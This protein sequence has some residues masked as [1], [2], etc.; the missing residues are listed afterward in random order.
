[1]PAQN[2]SPELLSLADRVGTARGSLLVVELRA[3]P[4]LRVSLETLPGESY[5]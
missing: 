4:L 5:A 1:M 3:L 2:R